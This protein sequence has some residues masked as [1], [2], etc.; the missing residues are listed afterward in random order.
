[1]WE[2][3]DATVTR[4]S[5][6]L[7][8]LNTIGSGQSFLTSVTRRARKALSVQ[9]PEFFSDNESQQPP[10]QLPDQNEEGHLSGGLC[11]LLILLVFLAPEVGLEP[12]TLRLTEAY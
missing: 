8:L 11:N 9:L 10:K 5:T 1:V 2:L 3:S 6:R 4:S 7:I 12:T